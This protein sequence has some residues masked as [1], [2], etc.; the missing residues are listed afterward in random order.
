MDSRQRLISAL[1]HKEP[2]RIP[3]DLGGV[4]VSLIHQNAQK[5]LA[6]YLEIS[7]PQEKIH[8]LMTMCVYTDERIKQRFHSDIELIQPGKPDSWELTIDPGTGKWSD[9]WGV[10]YKKPENVMYYEWDFQ[11]LQNAKDIS[12]IDKYIM[13]DPSDPGRYRGT[14]EKVEDIYNNTSKAMLVNS[15]YGIWEQTMTIRGLQNSL[16]DL[17]MN[18]K[19]IEYLAEK[20]LDWL[21]VYY[22]KM[23]SLVG[24]FVQVVKMDDDLGFKNGPL[25]SPEIYRKIY[26]PRHKT[27]VDFIRSK[28]DAKIFIHSDGSIYDFIPDFID[29]GIDIINP[30]EVTAANMDSSRLKKEFGRDI[31]F[32]GGGCDNKILE[33]GTPGQIEAEVKKR[34]SDFSP[35]GGFVFGSIHCIQP[36]VPP[37]NIAAL[38][39]SA[40]KYG[41][42]KSD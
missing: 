23:L 3:I 24:D 5:N 2:D 1:N 13:P 20:L 4:S 21:L 25:M 29:L 12:D 30:V 42:Y 16:M 35:D 27:I 6:E 17:A 9:D 10:V 33:K 41:F 36:F 34:V 37:E 22:D 7:D 38:F 19:F 31:S 11:P 14:K 8:N 28:T 18:K 26:K 32:W 40:Y 39:D 15:A